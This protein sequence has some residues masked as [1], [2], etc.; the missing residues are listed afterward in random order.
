MRIEYVH[1]PYA[2]ALG[3]TV[4]TD[5][6]NVPVDTESEIPKLLILH[7][8]DLKWCMYRKQTTSQPHQNLNFVDRSTN[9]AQQK[10]LNNY[11]TAFKGSA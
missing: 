6:Q 10:A 7:T 11:F 4:R 2:Y 3:W 9:T 1:T 5:V 8:I